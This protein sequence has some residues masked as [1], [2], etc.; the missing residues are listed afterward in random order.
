MQNF[1][2]TEALIIDQFPKYPE[3]CDFYIIGINQ[4][5][6]LLKNHL[7]LHSKAFFV[8]IYKY[9]YTFLLNMKDIFDK[10]TN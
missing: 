5:S 7:F 10:K 2:Q 4:R 8:Q 6:S 9:K 3:K 1:H